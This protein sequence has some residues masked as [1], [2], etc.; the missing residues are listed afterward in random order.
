MLKGAQGDIFFIYIYSCYKRQQ[1]DF[2]LVKN[3]PNHKLNSSRRSCLKS[4]MQ[5]PGFPAEIR[6]TP[7]GLQQ[8]QKT[9]EAGAVT[10][11]YMSDIALLVR[12]MG[13]LG[14]VSTTDPRI[15][16][17]QKAIGLRVVG[18]QEATG[19][20]KL[21][22]SLLVELFAFALYPRFLQDCYWVP[23]NQSTPQMGAYS[24]PTPF[25]L[26][27]F[28]VLE[29][30]R[31]TAAYKLTEEA[32][33]IWRVVARSKALQL[34]LYRM[35]FETPPAP[36]WESVEQG[37]ITRR[38]KA[39]RLKYAGQGFSPELVRWG[40]FSR[41]I[42][43][44][45]PLEPVQRG[46]YSIFL[47]NVLAHYDL[48]QRIQI[49]LKL[50]QAE[51][52]YD[53]TYRHQGQVLSFE[54]LA[55]HHYWDPS[56]TLDRTPEKLY[57]DIRV[58]INAK[59][60]KIDIR[61]R[62]TS[63]STVVVFKQARD[64]ED[65]LDLTLWLSSVAEPQSLRSKQPSPYHRSALRALAAS[66]IFRIPTISYTSE[67]GG[68]PPWVSTHQFALSGQYMLWDLP[69]EAPNKFRGF[70]SSIVVG[71]VFW[72]P[73]F[74]M[75][76]MDCVLA[77]KK[78]ASQIFSIV[79]FSYNNTTVLLYRVFTVKSDLDPLI[80][81]LPI[82]DDR[83]EDYMIRPLGKGMQHD[84]LLHN[85]THI[86]TT[87][88]LSNLV[89]IED[90]E[91]VYKVISEYDQLPPFLLKYN[92]F[93]IASLAR[94]KEYQQRPFGPRKDPAQ[95]ARWNAEAK[96]V[97]DKVG[98]LLRG[99]VIEEI[100]ST[101]FKSKGRDRY[102]HAGGKDIWMSSLRIPIATGYA[103]GPHA[104]LLKIDAHKLVGLGRYD[105]ETVAGQGDALAHKK[106]W[107]WAE[108]TAWLRRGF[109]LE[110]AQIMRKDTWERNKNDPLWLLQTIYESHFIF[111]ET[112]TYADY[113]KTIVSVT[114]TAANGAQYTVPFAGLDLNRVLARM[115]S[116]DEED[117]DDDGDDVDDEDTT[118]P[119]EFFIART[120]VAQKL[121][122]EKWRNAMPPKKKWDYEARADTIRKMQATGKQRFS[123]KEYNEW[124]RIFFIMRKAMEKTYSGPTHTIEYYKK[125]TLS[126]EKLRKRGGRGLSKS[127]QIELA[128]KE[129]ALQKF[130]E[131]GKK[132]V[133]SEAF[134]DME[135][136]F[137]WKIKAEEKL[138]KEEKEGVRMSIGK[139]IL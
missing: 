106:Y 45:N 27:E 48:K 93:V 115:E 61:R 1:L 113:L 13:Q 121:M 100:M 41:T 90:D 40:V 103:K 9:K 63:E 69:L 54:E 94:Q 82:S 81:F 30:H 24:C 2:R 52:R 72:P 120:G 70:H 123:F 78:Q 28:A 97:A 15:R 33:N 73:H 85:F 98:F 34:R 57:R 110:Q 43:E 66:S 11:R 79:L 8:L 49:G 136:A 137:E 55:K 32:S 86:K 132:E 127:D 10:A 116:I 114:Y 5:Q 80:L 99:T 37:R 138:A 4:L 29:M 92:N 36:F 124:L 91:Q 109:S 128:A 53:L 102:A 47:A 112:T 130:V 6:E 3:R 75:D 76:L 101:D 104:V 67:A 62:D 108:E 17:M 95:V 38:E 25:R 134:T 135:L 51:R 21:T 125:H 16:E 96:R 22:T 50:W 19:S 111:Y 42:P 122:L 46:W 77:S 68:V 64:E 139:M 26:Q 35:W 89:A 56:S 44:L 58:I 87:D 129:K 18:V 71:P 117:N 74:D 119:L 31:L 20:H 60:H 107:V 65:P 131:M 105:T 39:D 7:S 84:T 133:A 59:K 14:M 83:L 126:F 23:M 88:H 12:E 118:F